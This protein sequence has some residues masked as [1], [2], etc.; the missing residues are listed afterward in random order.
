MFQGKCSHMLNRAAMCSVHSSSCVMKNSSSTCLSSHPWKWQ[1]LWV[2]LHAT[3]AGSPVMWTSLSTLSKL[4]MYAVE[5]SL[6]L[7][8]LNPSLSLTHLSHPLT[9]RIATHSKLLT[10][11]LIHLL[12]PSLS[13]KQ[14]PEPTVLDTLASW[15]LS[16]ISSLVK[17]VLPQTPMLRDTILQQSKYVDIILFFWYWMQTANYANN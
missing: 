5:I 10:H 4:S 8:C 2:L 3:S 17:S 14:E 9:I 13:Y 7:L 11:P 16:L 1:E 12:Y 6:S 15:Y